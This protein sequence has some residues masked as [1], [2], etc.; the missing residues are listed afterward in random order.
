[1]LFTRR[2]ISKHDMSILFKQI[3]FM[4]TAGVS[5]SDC[6]D[7]LSRDNKKNTHEVLKNINSDILNGFSLSK[8]FERRKIF[9]SLVVNMLKA[10]EVSGNISKT[11]YE[12]SNYYE[13]E[14]KLISN[15]IHAASYPL[16]V[17][18]VAISVLIMSLT[19]VIPGYAEM[20]GD[21]QLPMTTRIVLKISFIIKNYYII[22]LLL[23]ILF[24]V[25]IYLFLKSHK[26]QFLF[27]YSITKNKVYV[28]YINFIF[29]CVVHMLFDANVDIVLT[30]KLVKSIIKNKFLDNIFDEI[31]LKVTQGYNLSDTIKKYDIFDRVLFSMI[32]IGEKTGKLSDT[33]LHCERYFRFRLNNQLEKLEKLI[34]PTLTILTGIIL[35]I[36]MLA[37]LEPTLSIGD[38]I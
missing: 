6:I 36:I 38:I 8:A 18:F 24:C 22:L 33:M 11:M 14:C 29:A 5:I 2:K 27:G 3:Y 26:G 16:I 25:C 28:S 9:N 17:F 19:F 4:T 32:E 15:F 23:L 34:E 30:I 1:M 12:L 37:I 13:Q 10:G 31:A 21:M 20:F 7:F 35:G